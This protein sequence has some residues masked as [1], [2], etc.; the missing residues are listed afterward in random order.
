MRPRLGVSSRLLR[1]SGG[2]S[3]RSE[4]GYALSWT[5]RA[6]GLEYLLIM[7]ALKGGVLSSCGLMF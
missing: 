7:A 1:V 6:L 5:N 3:A 2:S 4:E